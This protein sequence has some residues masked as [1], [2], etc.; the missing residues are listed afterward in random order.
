MVCVLTWSSYSFGQD[1]LVS[2]VDSLECVQKDLGDALRNV[3][4]KAPKTKVSKGGSLLLFPIIGSNPATGFMIGVGGQYAFQMLNSEK[5]SALSG[6][7][8]YTTKGQFLFYLKNN[9]YTKSDRFFLSGDWRFLIFSQSTYGLGTNAPTSGIL[10]YQYSLAGMEVNSDSLAQPMKFDFAR[11]H[12]NVSIKLRK[13]LYLGLG[14]NLDAY[15]KII[16]EKLS[17][18]DGD[19]LITSHYAYSQNYDFNKEEYFSSS[20][21]VNVLY[22]SRDNMINPYKGIFAKVSWQG[23][24]RWLGSDKTGNFLQAELRTF[25]ALSKRNPRHLI[26]FWL[27][28]DFTPEGD[29]PYMI[30][31][32]TAYDQRGRSG[33]G[34][35]Q[36]RFRGNNLVYGEAEYRFPLS[37]CGGMWGGVLFLNATSASSPVHDLKLLDSVKPGYGLGL[38]LAV[39]K[40]SRTNLA[41]DLG[42]GEKSFG[43]YLAASET[44]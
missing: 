23:A 34:Y 6:S 24:F 22:D 21:N 28:G 12:Q 31:P 25:H 44:F 1:S 17:L 38:R 41:L 15:F 2:S 16:D 42:W 13:S 3:L 27:L 14:Y 33:R 37:K 5:F 26:A 43:F 18:N 36:G 19:T 40:K 8:Q 35:T 4:G 30:L 11:L 32:A 9:I 39:D 29:F 7:L 20:L 10:Q